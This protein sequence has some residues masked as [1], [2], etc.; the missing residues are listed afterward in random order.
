MQTRWGTIAVLG[1]A[2]LLAACAPPPESSTPP[3]SNPSTS[4]TSGSNT[5]PSTTPT[6]PIPTLPLSFKIKL[7]WSA[8]STRADGSPLPLSEIS[9]YRVYYLLEGTDSS[10]DTTISINGGNTTTLNLTLTT[11][12][13]YT[14]AITTVDRN[15]LES[16]LSSAV[17]VPIN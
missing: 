10:N 14:F 5:K 4:P 8:P 17:S 9:G 12:G 6:L 3:A 2:V 15:G 13:S 16:K 1:L 11:A 7:N